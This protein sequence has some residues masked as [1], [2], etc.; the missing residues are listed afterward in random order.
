MRSL[1][2]FFTED[3]RAVA[4]VIGFVLLFGIAV[5]AFSGYQAVQVPQQNAETEFRHQE[6]VQN[7]LIVLRNAISR[8]GQ[9]NERQFESVRLGTTYRERSFAL[10]PPAPAGTLRTLG[11]HTI[12]IDNGT[13]NRTVE[14]QF[15]Q[16]QDGYNELDAN[17]IYYEHSVLYLETETGNR[18]F[19]EDQNLV[20]E[21]S[22][23]VITAL[24]RDFSRSDTGRVTIELYPTE[25]GDQLPTGE[26]DV[27]LPTRLPEDYWQEQLGGT[28]PI[29]NI[30]YNDPEGDIREVTFTVN[31]SDLEF[32][33]VG[34]N[35][36]PDQTGA[37]SDMDGGG[38]GGGGGEVGG[39]NGQC[40]LGSNV[41]SNALQIPNFQ[42]FETRTN[43]NNNK[44][45]LKELQVQDNDGDNDLDQVKF[46][47]TD[48]G[49]TTRATKTLDISGQN[50]QLSSNIEFSPDDSSYTVQSGE[51]Y[52]LTATACDTD[53]NSLTEQIDS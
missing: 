35:D 3:T 41:N 28:D 30:G 53:G 20:R 36:A 44:W 7:D 52:T 4:P 49:G 13:S 46:E 10:N 29:S 39:E 19:F 12:T 5:V 42:K 22:D 31:S 34:I 38:G 1:D 27:T 37:V 26:L 45:R 15:L 2:S 47:I 16:Y 18:V 51:T 24:Q 11:P 33:T 17:P 21:N 9:Q 23:V 6:K 40:V 48:S 50:Y 32:N 8:A 14:T 43:G 25:A